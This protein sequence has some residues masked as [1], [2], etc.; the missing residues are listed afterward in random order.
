[1]LWRRR[2]SAIEVTNIRGVLGG[3]KK[4]RGNE[5]RRGL[6]VWRTVILD[7]KGRVGLSEKMTR[8]KDL[9]EERLEAM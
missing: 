9:K 7:R 6:G 8:S 3:D 4:R 2:E 1:M 5:E